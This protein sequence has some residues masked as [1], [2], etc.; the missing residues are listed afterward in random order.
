MY[1]FIFPRFFIAFWLRR[2]PFRRHFCLCPITRIS[3]HN[4]VTKCKKKNE[5]RSLMRLRLD[6]IGD[7][8]VAF[9]VVCSFT[10]HDDFH[11]VCFSLPLCLFHCKFMPD[12]NDKL[13]HVSVVHYS[14]IDSICN[15]KR[16]TITKKLFWSCTKRYRREVKV[17]QQTICNCFLVTKCYLTLHL[18]LHIAFNVSRI[19]E[20]EAKRKKM[21]LKYRCQ[22]HQ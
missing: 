3:G 17:C 11:F 7:C 8:R 20:E 15:W 4:P 13:E 16:E 22:L 14:N 5:N 6:C 19:N 9:P 1:S 12:K 10:A 2:M 18:R 21:S